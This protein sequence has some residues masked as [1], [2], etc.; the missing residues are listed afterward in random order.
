MADLVSLNAKA[1]FETKKATLGH[2]AAHFH[3]LRYIDATT[4]S[5]Q[6]YQGS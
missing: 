2:L 6:P 5:Y 3:G 1:N 4:Y